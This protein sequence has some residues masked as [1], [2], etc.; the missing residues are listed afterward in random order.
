MRACGYNALYL[1]SVE[2]GYVLGGHHLENE[3]VARSTRWITRA[4][5]FATQNSVVD[6]EMVQDL[7]KGLGNFLSALVKTTGTSYPKQYVRGFAFGHHFGHGGYVY[8][9]SFSMPFLLFLYRSGPFKSIVHSENCHGAMLFSTL[10]NITFHSLGDLASSI[11]WWR[12]SL[13][14]MSNGLMLT[15]HSSTQALQVLQASSSSLVV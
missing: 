10:P 3:L 11:I 7:N 4:G 13:R 14:I 1:V 12:R 5:F 15:G 9:C 6:V 8:L 2:C